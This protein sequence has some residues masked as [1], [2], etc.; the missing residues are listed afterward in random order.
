MF[1]RVGPQTDY[2]RWGIG[3]GRGPG[4]PPPFGAILFWVQ[5]KPNTANLELR[6]QWA[7]ARHVQRKI[8]MEGTRSYDVLGIALAVERHN[9][10]RIIRMAM[11]EA[12]T[13]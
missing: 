9:I 10:F 1:V 3:T 5:E 13:S 7:L 11:K 4:K 2:A 12:M 8:A 6:D